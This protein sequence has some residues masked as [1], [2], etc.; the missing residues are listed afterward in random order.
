M[1]GQPYNQSPNLYMGSAPQMQQR[2][3]YLTQQQQA[4]GQVPPV[5][6]NYFSN[7]AIILK[8]RPVT[9]IEEA[10]AAQIDLDGTSTFFPCIA[11][12]KIY[13]KSIDLN[14]LPIFR[15]YEL[16]ETPKDT[17]A[18]ATSEV[19][20]NLKTRIDQLEQVIAKMK[21]GMKNESVPINANGAVSQQPNGYAPTSNGQQPNVTT[22]N[23]NGTGK[24]PRPVTGNSQEPR[25][26]AWYE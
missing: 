24:E 13:E 16:Q 8:G 6:N 5:T 25:T 11:E 4:Y 19:V 20:N 1:Y 12:K 22:S 9:N 23:A 14:G 3:S 17:P 7:G 18:Y 21:G 2:L 15:V 10:K 26:P